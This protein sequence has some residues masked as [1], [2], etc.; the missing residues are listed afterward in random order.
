MD[1]DFLLVPDYL[2]SSVSFLVVSEYLTALGGKQ[3]QLGVDGGGVIPIHT[4][5]A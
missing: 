2:L 5:G 3:S 4:V 1:D